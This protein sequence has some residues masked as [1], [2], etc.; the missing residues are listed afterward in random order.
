M[1]IFGLPEASGGLPGANIGLFP[2]YIGLYRPLEASQG[3]PEGPKWPYL[4]SQRP[5][6]G[7]PEGSQG[8]PEGPI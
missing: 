4:A 2:L 1:A 8:L 7:L 6:R 5:P 3:L